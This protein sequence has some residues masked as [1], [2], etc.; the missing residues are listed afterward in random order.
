MDSMRRLYDNVAEYYESAIAPLVGPLARN[1][2]DSIPF[3]LTGRRV[4]DVGTGTGLAARFLA[5]RTARPIGIDLSPPMLRVA[6]QINTEIDY[7]QANAVHLPFAD[8]TFDLVVSSFGLNLTDP[9][10]S[11]KEIR[12]V[13]K[14]GGWLIGQEW[15]AR[16]SLSEGFD[17]QFDRLVPLD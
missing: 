9:R 4:L 6:K 5:E 17:Q 14:R 1:L 3:F 13:L 8:A 10:Q 7:I 11:L 16:D 2:I 12:R 15:A